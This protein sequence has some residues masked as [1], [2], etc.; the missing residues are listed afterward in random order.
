MAASLRGFVDLAQEIVSR[1]SGG[2][3]ESAWIPFGVRL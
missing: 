1:A 3:I 2:H